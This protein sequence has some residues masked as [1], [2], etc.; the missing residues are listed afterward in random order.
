MIVRKIYTQ[1]NKTGTGNQQDRDKRATIVMT[2]LKAVTGRQRYRDERATT[3]TT[4]I[5]GSAF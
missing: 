5:N 2:S 4:E 3:V 1:K